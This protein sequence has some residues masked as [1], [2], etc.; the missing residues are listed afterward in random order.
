M[1]R[2]QT[3]GRSSE[4]EVGEDDPLTIAIDPRPLIHRL[5]LGNAPKPE[6]L[7]TWDEPSRVQA[8]DR[9]P[10]VL[11]LRDLLEAR[12]VPHESPRY[13]RSVELAR[14][15]AILLVNN[16]SLTTDEDMLWYFGQH[17]R[18]AE[19]IARRGIVSLRVW[20]PETPS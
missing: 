12:G 8:I 3:T 4:R 15:G 20:V 17:Q 14:K 2:D 10:E 11:H 19:S 16:V 6:G 1:M 9:D 5:R 7:L 18:L 13:R